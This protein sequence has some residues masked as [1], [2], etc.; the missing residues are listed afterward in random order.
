MTPEEKEADNLFRLLNLVVAH[1]VAQALGKKSID[2]KLADPF[3]QQ[4]HLLLIEQS[5]ADV[6][7]RR[8]RGAS[9]ASAK[10]PEVRL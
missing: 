3:A 8:Q 10:S 2:A 5:R 4:L 6:R 7:A 9:Q 1:R